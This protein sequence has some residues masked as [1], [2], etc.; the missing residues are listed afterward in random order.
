[1]MLSQVSVEK[2]GDATTLSAYVSHKTIA[3][4]LGVSRATV[5]FVL[6]GKAEEKRISPETAAKVRQLA[7]E[8]DYVPNQ[9]ALSL[10]RKRSGMIGVSIVDFHLDWAYRLHQGLRK[11]LADSGTVPLFVPRGADPLQER[12]E[13]NWLVGHR[14][15][16]LM[17]CVG[18]Q[19]NMRIHAELIAGGMP[20]VYVADM[21]TDMPMEPNYVMWD[22]PAAMRELVMQVANT[23][24]HRMVWAGLES[25]EKMAR[26]RFSAYRRA[27]E[28]C[29]ST[30]PSVW[31]FLPSKKT[32]FSTPRMVDRWIEEVI[33]P[34]LREIDVIVCVNDWMAFIVLEALSN[35]GISVPHDVVVTGV[36][37]QPISGEFYNQLITIR[38]PIEEMGLRGGRVLM[39]IITGSKP[40]PIQEMIPAGALIDRAGIL[41]GSPE[42]RSRRPIPPHMAS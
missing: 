38:E 3:S 11:A 20:L 22:S 35:A 32:F 37:D 1:M 2:I 21:P 24:R 31:N 9:M 18:M 13:L 29:G 25:H 39:E 15:D 12:K 23:G 4:K 17:I 40:Q 6:N 5:S 28:E 10:K 8:L 14:V 7:R 36:G 41:P 16:G 34:N 27:T 19:E 42:N 30:C 33:R 26:A